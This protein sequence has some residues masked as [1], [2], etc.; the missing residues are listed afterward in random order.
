MNEYLKLV[1]ANI[2]VVSGTWATSFQ[3]VPIEKMIQ[4]ADAIM[5]GD[6]LNSKSVELEDGTIATEARFKIEK[7]TGL[8][9]E[10][11]G[12]SE[13]KV[14]YP[15]GKIGRKHVAVEGVPE[16]VSGEKNVLFL[17]QLEDGR[18]W[19][20]GLAMGTFK[21]V[22]IGQSTLLINSVFPSNPELSRI[23]M[24]KFLRKVSSTKSQGLKEIHSDKYMHE[25]QKD[26]TRT[27]SVEQTGN[28]RS[29]ASKGGERENKNEPNLMNS[30]WLIIL[31][32]ALGG[33]SAWWGRHRMR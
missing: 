11:F 6:F 15:G 20:Q 17:N 9:A 16:F 2:L 32:G 28:S 3:P 23:E 26:R 29:I 10:E 7:E 18:L 13:I 24:S 30:F 5:I 4:P 1:L 19:I 33:I 31:L 21:V 22:K 8:D 14:Y 27:V 12:L 25:L